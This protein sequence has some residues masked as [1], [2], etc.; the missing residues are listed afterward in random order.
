MARNELK[1]SLRKYSK[2]QTPGNHSDYI[3]KKQYLQNLIKTFK[4]KLYQKTSE[5][6]NLSKDANQFWHK[7][8]K[9]LKTKRDNVIDPMYDVSSKNYIFKDEIISII[10]YNHHI[11]NNKIN[12]Y[13]GYFKNYKL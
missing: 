5:Y 12:N 4:F 3:F 6:L 8:E 11:N 2:R 9:V 13:D 10:L 1:S 7:Y